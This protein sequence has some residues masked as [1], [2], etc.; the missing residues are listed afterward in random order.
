MVGLSNVN[1]GSKMTSFLPVETLERDFSL[2]LAEGEANAHNKTWKL[3]NSCIMGKWSSRN[4]W[5][6]SVDTCL[7]K[8][9]STEAILHAFEKVAV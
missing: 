9:L 5:R 8:C 3:P 2:E 7:H 1:S 6:A 4:V